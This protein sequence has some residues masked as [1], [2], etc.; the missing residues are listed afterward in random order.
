LWRALDALPIA[1][2]IENFESRT[3]VDA[4]L[5]GSADDAVF[6]HNMNRTICTDSGGALM[7][8]AYIIYNFHVNWPNGTWL[9]RDKRLPRKTP[10]QGQASRNMGGFRSG[11][12]ISHGYNLIPLDVLETLKGKL[13]S[14]ETA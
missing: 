14:L 10:Q 1:C 11:K 8:G 5:T 13:T 3:T 12:C 2:K 9:A 4:I 7:I 6:V